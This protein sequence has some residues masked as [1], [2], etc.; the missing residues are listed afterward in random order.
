MA[1]KVQIPPDPPFPCP[2]RFSEELSNDYRRARRKA[3]D[4]G[5]RPALIAAVAAVVATN[6][7]L[8]YGIF[9]PNPEWFFRWV[10]LLEFAVIAALVVTVFV[11][12]LVF[13]YY[14][15]D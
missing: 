7:N 3:V 5:F 9:S 13:L 14:L 1:G 6:Q 4:W 15:F 2:M 12:A 11:A 10:A 8:M